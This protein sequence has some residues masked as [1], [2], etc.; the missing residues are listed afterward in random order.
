M[1]GGDGKG[2]Q[3]WEKPGDR[4]EPYLIIVTLLSGEK[5]SKKV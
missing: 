4:Q 3:T 1:I 5:N 2:V